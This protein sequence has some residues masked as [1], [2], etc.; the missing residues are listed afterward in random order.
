MVRATACLT[1]G[2][3]LVSVA[4]PVAS[5]AGRVPTANKD[6]KRLCAACGQAP[7]N[8]MSALP[9][10]EQTC[11][12]VW[13]SRPGRPLEALY[14]A[15]TYGGALRRAVLAYKYRADLRWARV[16]A[17]VLLD[18]LAR[19]ATWFE[20]Y[21]VLCPV[22]AYT[23]AGARRAWGHVE[24]MCT[25]LAS[26]ASGEWPVEQLVTKVVETEPMSATSQPE[27]RRIAAQ[28]LPGSFVPA[29]GAAIEGRKVL[30]VDDVCA[31]G[32]TLLSVAGALSRAGAEEVVGLVLARATFRS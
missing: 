13:C 9:A 18:F 4:V 12:N 19:H 27:R 26:L 6:V 1:L 5:S 29:R 8:S 15:G 2:A 17:R 31:S 3:Q 20:E 11:R 24:L 25:E 7:G 23:G 21:A 14:W 16:F 32:E 30:V 28:S 22:P 10:G